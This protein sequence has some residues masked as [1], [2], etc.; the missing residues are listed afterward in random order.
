VNITLGNSY[1]SKFSFIKYDYSTSTSIF[2][3]V[4]HGRTDMPTANLAC[5]PAPPMDKNH[6]ISTLMFC[7]FRIYLM[8]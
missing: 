4:F 5:L 3:E 1:F 2:T 7:D 8:L 6:E